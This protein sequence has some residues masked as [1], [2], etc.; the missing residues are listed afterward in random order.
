MT[1][2]GKI[3]RELQ[4]Q[5]RQAGRGTT[6]LMTLY[7]LEGF[8]SR[9]A[10]SQYREQLVLKG[11]VLLAAWNARR[12][13]RDIDFAALNTSNETKNIL[14]ICCDIASISQ[15]D[16]ITFDTASATAI[17]IRD[18]DEYS[19]VR[20]SMP[21]RIATA[22]IAFHIDIN[23]G[24]PIVPGAVQVDYPRILNNSIR[25]QLLGYPISMVL[26]EKIVTAVQRGTASTRWRDFG[27][28]YNLS[29]IHSISLNEINMSIAAV[30]D[31]RLVETVALREVLS[32][33]SQIGQT[34]YENWR[35]K[36]DR[37]E[38]PE[39]FGELLDAIYI[40]TDPVLDDRAFET[41]MWDPLRSVWY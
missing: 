1:T 17:A 41:S 31:H 10:E 35:I 15:V 34:K 6:E 28:I 25:I 3:Y 36:Q 20:V 29:R 18:D 4:R 39:D 32:D 38:L 33:Y 11:G 24:D 5:A 40:F 8:L 30:S 21:A 16:G 14:D 13:T 27:D 7:V 12:P 22:Q 37:L 9:V 23:V 2:E 19:G 26:A